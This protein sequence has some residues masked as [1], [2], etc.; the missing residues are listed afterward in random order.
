MKQKKYTEAYGTLTDE[1]LLKAE[2]YY[3]QNEQKQ[4]YKTKI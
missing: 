1:Q 2:N 4:F 3:V